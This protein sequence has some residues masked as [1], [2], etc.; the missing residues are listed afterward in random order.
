MPHIRQ[1]TPDPP[2][3]SP[4]PPSHIFSL[5][6]S[7]AFLN[8]LPLPRLD[9]SAILSALRDSLAGSSPGPAALNALESGAEMDEG[10][11]SHA[12][13]VLRTWGVVQGWLRV[14]EAAER[15][16]TRWTVGVGGVLVAC[17]MAVSLAGQG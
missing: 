14:G 4:S 3:H 6:L 8:L 10:V 5:S 11:L 1:L 12:L 9:G 15:A 13:D 2:P 7:L 17:T 16:L